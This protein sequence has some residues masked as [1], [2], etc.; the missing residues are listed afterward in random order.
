MMVTTYSKTSFNPN[1]LTLIMSNCLLGL[2]TVQSLWEIWVFFPSKL[3]SSSK[4]KS[5]L[6]IFLVNASS[7]KRFFFKSHRIHG[8]GIF[9]RFT[10]IWLIFKGKYTT[11]MDTMGFVKI[12]QNNP[13]RLEM[14]FTVHT[15]HHRKAI[16]PIV[17]P[18]PG[19][20]VCLRSSE[21]GMIQDT[22]S[23]NHGDPKP[24]THISGQIIIFHQP[25]FLWNK[26]ISRL[27]NH[28]LGW[29]RV[30]SL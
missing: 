10:Y 29:G 24:L 16:E 25:G 17:I 18:I 15:G 4:I 20:R 2:V 30:R 11:P 5:I 21:L 19:A 22:W 6:L 28:H 26:G 9:T 3:P 27:L 8:T 1:I 23:T 13:K 12:C 14:Y 7:S